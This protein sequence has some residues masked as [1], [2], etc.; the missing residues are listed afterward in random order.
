[1]VEAFGYDI[2]DL[3]SFMLN[4]LENSWLDNT[5]KNNLSK[6]WFEEFDDLQQQYFK[7]NKFLTIQW[8][9]LGNQIVLTT[10]FS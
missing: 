3:K 1:M 10:G 7:S 5:T 6:E 9:S 8:F 2:D 4:G